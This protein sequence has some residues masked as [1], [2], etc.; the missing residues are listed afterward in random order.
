MSL[1]AR[2][3][4]Q[5]TEHTLHVPRLEIKTKHTKALT[6]HAKTACQPED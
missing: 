6:A 5:N 2:T 1:E 3:G 4:K